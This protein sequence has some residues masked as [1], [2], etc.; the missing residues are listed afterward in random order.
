MATDLAP[1]VSSRALHKGRD[2]LPVPCALP[3]GNSQVNTAHHYRY[4][5]GL[6]PQDVRPYRRGSS[7]IPQAS[8]RKCKSHA[9]RIYNKPGWSPADNAISCFDKYRIRCGASWFPHDQRSRAS[10]SPPPLAYAD[11]IRNWSCGSFAGLG[12]KQPKSRHSRTCNSIEHGPISAWTLSSRSRDRTDALLN[13]SFSYS[14][15]STMSRKNQC[16]DAMWQR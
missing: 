6:G 4:V 12:R 2:C 1:Q 7:Q 13:P 15:A 5:R 11:G 3:I 10:C 9:R 8:G 16:L 14:G